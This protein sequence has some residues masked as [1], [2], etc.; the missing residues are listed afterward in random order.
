MTE[1]PGV[2][3]SVQGLSVYGRHN[4]TGHGCLQIA[5]KTVAR[6]EGDGSPYKGQGCTQ[7]VHKT[8]PGLCTK[9][10][11]EAS[12][13]GSAMGVTQKEERTD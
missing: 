3:G 7:N 12:E 4:E 13:E 2:S 11:Q 5:N 6:R 1:D 8:D 9:R 10:K